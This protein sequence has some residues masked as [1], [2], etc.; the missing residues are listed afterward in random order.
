VINICKF[1]DRPRKLARSHI[2]PE[3]LLRPTFDELGRALAIRT[4]GKS[5]RLVQQAFQYPLLCFDCERLFNEQ[6]EMPFYNVWYARN[7]APQIVFGPVYRL[8][9]PD[10]T[11]FKLFFLSVLWRSAACPVFPFENV[12][13]GDFAA[14]IKSMLQNASPGSAGLL[15]LVGSV[16]HAP[17]SLQVCHA[18]ASPFSAPWEDC[19]A[20]VLTFGG[21]VWHVLLQDRE[22]PHYLRGWALQED[23]K[24]ALPVNDISS[25]RPL[26]ESFSAYVSLAKEKAWRNPWQK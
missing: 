25:V 23:G 6:F 13:I 16:I 1:C 4:S 22:L 12:E 17:D 7:T 20:Y 5:A 15:T 11:R 3:F 9:L 14:R 10:Y 18:V 21:C 8:D 19:E 24:M 26:H 2:I